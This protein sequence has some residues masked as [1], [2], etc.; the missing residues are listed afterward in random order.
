MNIQLM[1]NSSE[2]NKINKLL[3][4]VDTLEGSLKES[5]S[6]IDPVI[7]I[8]YDDPTAF[9]YCY[10][11]VFHRYYY[12][13]NVTVIHHNIMQLTLHVDVLTSFKNE[14]LQQAIIMDKNTSNFD[15]YL[16]DNNRIVNVKTKTDI[17]NFPYGLLESG[18]FILITAGG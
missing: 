2:K 13:K 11:E 7:M 16:I 18:Q 12:V 4:T 8:E 17:M 14:I 1:I 15:N 10:I 3:T 9:N 5:S 6:I